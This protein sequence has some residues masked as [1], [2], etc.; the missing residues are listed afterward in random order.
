MSQIAAVVAV[1]EAAF[2]DYSNR[3][4]RACRH[5][6]EPIER[7]AEWYPPPEKDATPRLTGI[8]QMTTFSHPAVLM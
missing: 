2:Q 4:R 6:L 7:K 8:S 5:H 3:L 1:Y